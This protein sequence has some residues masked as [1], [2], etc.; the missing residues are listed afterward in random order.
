[1]VR[2]QLYVH[3][4]G[5]EVCLQ[6]EK[7]KNDIFEEIHKN[8]QHTLIMVYKGCMIL[9]TRGIPY[10]FQNFGSFYPLLFFQMIEKFLNFLHNSPK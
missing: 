10:I 9:K 7:I 8:E 6:K 4:G 2:R 5:F 3:W 1:M